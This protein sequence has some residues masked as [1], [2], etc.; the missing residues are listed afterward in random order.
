MS[1]PDVVFF[2][3]LHVAEYID[4]SKHD[5]EKVVEVSPNGR[6]AKV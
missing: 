2:F 4:H 1:V 6:Y 5:P 3:P